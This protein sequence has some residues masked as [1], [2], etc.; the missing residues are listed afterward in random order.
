MIRGNRNQIHTS[1]C[2]PNNHLAVAVVMMSL[3]MIVV[4][5]KQNQ[6]QLENGNKGMTS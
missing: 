3:E 6:V 4:E 5:S 1:F 2:Y